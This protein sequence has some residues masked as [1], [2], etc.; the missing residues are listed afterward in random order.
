MVAQEDNLREHLYPNQEGQ[1]QR[2]QAPERQTP[3]PERPVSVEEMRERE[4]SRAEERQQRESAIARLKRRVRSPRKK[5]QIPKIQDEITEEIERILEQ[6]LKDAYKNLSP[7]Q[8]QEFKIKGEILSFELRHMLRQ[9]HVK[10]KKVF[11]LIANWLKLLPGVNKFFLEQEA[12]IKADKIMH[13]K[14][15]KEGQL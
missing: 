7:L 8:R 12:K 1:E 2:Y 9:T 10:F 15:E 11:E 14:E 3:T 13:I 5:K 4:Q 6:D